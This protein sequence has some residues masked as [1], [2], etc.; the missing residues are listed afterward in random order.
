MKVSLKYIELNRN[1]RA[2]KPNNNE[3]LQKSRYPTRWW[4]RKLSNSVESPNVANSVEYENYV[5]ELG[6]KNRSG[7]TPVF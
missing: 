1:R 4:M 3:L 2:W 7:K 5:A 6:G